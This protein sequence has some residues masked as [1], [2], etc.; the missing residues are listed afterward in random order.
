M[1]G[2]SSEARPAVPS[3]A[4][5]PFQY[6]EERDSKGVFLIITSVAYGSHSDTQGQTV[7]HDLGFA[8]YGIYEW[9]RDVAVSPFQQ[10]FDQFAL[11]LDW[12]YVHGIS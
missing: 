1:G 5:G 8:R 6:A 7:M 11:R 3:V 10:P 4:R 12:E 9:I 2:L